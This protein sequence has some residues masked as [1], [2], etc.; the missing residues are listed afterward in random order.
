LKELLKM[1]K[2][3]MKLAAAMMLV[4]GTSVAM[5][6]GNYLLLVADTATVTGPIRTSLLG[7]G[8][9]TNVDIYPF[10]SS[11]PTPTL[12]ELMMYDAVIT[13]SNSS[14]ADG[15]A[16]GNVLADYVD[17]GGGVVCAVYV[18]SS[19]TANRS[20]TGRWQTGG[21]DLIV[22]RSGTTTTATSLG[23]VHLPGHPVWANMTGLTGSTNYARSTTFDLTAHAVRI[24]DWTD[25][26]VLAATSSTFP[27]RVD[28]N[29]YPTQWHTA[30]DGARLIANALIA[31]AA[32]G[33]TDPGRCCLPSGTCEV[34]APAACL[35]QGGSYGGAGTDCTLACPQPGAC[36]F[37]DGTCQSILEL[38]CTSSGGIWSGAGIDCVTANC[39][40]PATGACC[41]AS[42]C[43]IV[44]IFQCDALSGI[45]RGDN[46]TCAAACNGLFFEIEPN[47]TKLEA[48][49][50]TLASGESLVG[51]STAATGTADPASP[52]YFRIKT[53]AAPLGIYRHRM[54]MNNELT[55]GGS[56]WIRGLTQT[57]AAAGPWPG[58]VGTATTTEST[59]QTHLLEGTARVNY[60]YGFGKE[61][62]VYY[63]VSGVASTTGNYVATL[64]TEPVIPTNLGSFQAG[65]IAI[66]T[67]GMGHTSDTSVRIYDQNLNPIHGFAN[68]RASINGG[69]PAN[70]TNTSFL[71]RE[72]MPG[73]YYMGIT[74]GTF[75]SDQGAPCD[76]NIRTGA[77]MDFPDVAVNVGALTTT[78]VSFQVIDGSGATP[79]T[80][81][82]GGRGEIAWFRFEAAGSVETGACC[83]IDGTCEILSPVGCGL[84]GGTY[85]GAN[86]DCATANCPQPPTGACCLAGGTCEIL[87][88]G[89]CNA[90]GGT[91][92]GDNTLCAS[93]TCPI[94]LSTLPGNNGLTAANGG[95][96]LDLTA[97]GSDALSVLRI[98]HTPNTAAGG[99]F[100]VEV[101]TYPGAYL[102]AYADPTGWTLH[103]T[104]STVSQGTTTPV[105]LQLATPLELAV[106]QT[107]GVY[108][109]ST[110]GGLRYTTGGATAPSTYADANLTL[111]SEHVRT[112]PWAGSIN[113]PR[114]LSGA[115]HYL[116]AGGT[117][118]YANCDGSTVEPVLNIDDFTCFINEYAN[119]QGLPHEQQVTAY[120]NCDG[121]TTAPALNIE[122]FT[123]FI[124][125][126]ALGCP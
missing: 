39:P 26:R 110:T 51:T 88:Q 93:V 78:D 3:R 53:P 49:I 92:M 54:T 118:C 13:W 1:A 100:V 64:S 59:G 121:S 34:L 46:T 68:D 89:A 111:F 15:A 41:S 55:P 62:E 90:Q 109:I 105:P 98:D 84:Q 16:M 20:L 81:A 87:W 21:Y 74:I 23:T 22:Q 11:L 37:P 44:N 82:R 57:A 24:A 25:G 75:S 71:L 8:Q 52:D 35:S 10:A 95:I 73:T 86:T 76:D 114:V 14:Y 27:N 123:C 94:V 91:Y 43:T 19:T 104:I 99:A 72:Y 124:N 125:S 85:Q 66:D 83:M 9:V 50:V 67:S 48:N 77:M 32:G 12:A 102:P 28:I 56:T 107:I 29:L 69:A 101:W 96:F 108:L 103:E 30:A 17:A 80:A 106:G 40:Q 65:F 122:D 7:T 79:I 119:A 42:G 31:A 58:P 2:N 60:W 47:N 117:S 5:G 4:A 113:T 112:L 115:I 120:A 18:V 97:S 70:S 63:R 36:C 126:Y 6:Q 116:V 45:Y 38:N 33:N 61:E